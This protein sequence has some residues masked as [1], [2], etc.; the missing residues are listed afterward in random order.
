[1]RRK[2]PGKEKTMP[3]S[4]CFREFHEIEIDE[5]IR[6]RQHHP[7]QD[8]EVFFHIYSDRDA[9]RFFERETY[10]GDRYTDGFVKVLE[11]R[12]KG[13]NRKTI[14]HGLLN[15]TGSRSGRFSSM[16]SRRKT[17]P[18]SSDIS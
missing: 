13:F 4:D 3:F 18:A 10:P 11:S 15:M 12:I 5:H 8:A 1:M 2:E 9:F 7:Q 16:I 17:R 6:L 14:I